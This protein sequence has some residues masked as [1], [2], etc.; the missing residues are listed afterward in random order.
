MFPEQ[1][2]ARLHPASNDF[3]ALVIQE[4]NFLS[5]IRD[6]EESEEALKFLKIQLSLKLFLN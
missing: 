5:R 2:S 4:V 6:L 3:L 1:Y